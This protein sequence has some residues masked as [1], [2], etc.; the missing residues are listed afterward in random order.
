MKWD[1]SHG[2]LGHVWQICL[3]FGRANRR[4]RGPCASA[5]PWSP[6]TIDDET[7]LDAG[8]QSYNIH[9]PDHDNN[10]ATD[11]HHGYCNHADVSR[12]NSY[13]Y[14]AYTD[15]RQGQNM[16]F[17]YFGQEFGLFVGIHGTVEVDPCVV[18]DSHPVWLLFFF[19][20]GAKG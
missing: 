17:W 15:W 9:V 12:P 19:F 7:Q 6:P 5:E 3:P 20:S 14:T 18:H 2:L 4:A 13:D 8:T 10:S 1:C 16:V 11:E